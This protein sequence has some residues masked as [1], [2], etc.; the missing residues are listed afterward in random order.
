MVELERTF[1]PVRLSVLQAVLR[2]AGIDSFVFDSA[3]GG[4]LQ[5]AIPARVMV[6]EDDVEMARWAMQQAEL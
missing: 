2:D 3:V 5:G 1:D 6:L 4:V